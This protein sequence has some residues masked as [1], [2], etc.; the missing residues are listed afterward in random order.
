MLITFHA[1]RTESASD[2][3]YIFDGNITT[4]PILATLFGVVAPGA[5]YRSSGRYML[6]R[7][8]SNS[9][10]EYG[11]FNASFTSSSAAGM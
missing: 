5:V 9:V 3:V 11:G 2:V 8:T 7:F 10:E 4:S 1:F 6:V